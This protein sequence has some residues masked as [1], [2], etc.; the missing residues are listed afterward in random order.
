MVFSRGGLP[1]ASWRV[2][3]LPPRQQDGLPL[4][5]NSLRTTGHR[6]LPR[7]PA[8]SSQ[9]GRAPHSSGVPGAPRGHA[10][11]SALRPRPPGGRSA[12]SPPCAQTA[13]HVCRGVRRG[14]WGRA[15]WRPLLSGPWPE[16]A[17]PRRSSGRGGES[18]H[19]RLSGRVRMTRSF[20][21]P[22]CDLQPAAAGFRFLF[23]D[24]GSRRSPTRRRLCLL[25]LLLPTSE[26][27]V[28]STWFRY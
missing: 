15:A 20:R 1:Q 19:P 4:V 5:L 8:P 22:P 21:G 27:K 28:L 14:A 2:A 3:S 6:R 7:A 18:A 23:C 12:S 13:P 16:G 9:R 17:G 11:L 24:G 26:W 25:P 10:P